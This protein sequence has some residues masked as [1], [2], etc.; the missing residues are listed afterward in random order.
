M[1]EG[2]NE[3]QATVSPLKAEGPDADIMTAS[4]SGLA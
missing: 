1:R 4:H 2:M 3:W